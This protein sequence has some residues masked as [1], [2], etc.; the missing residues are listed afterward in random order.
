MPVPWILWV[1]L[2]WW[3]ESGWKHR[4]HHWIVLSAEALGLIWMNGT[5]KDDDDI[6]WKSTWGPVNLCCH[7]DLFFGG[8]WKWWKQTQFNITQQSS[9]L[10]SKDSKRQR[11]NGQGHFCA[12]VQ[13]LEE[14]E[15][16]GC[17]R[18]GG[19]CRL[20]WCGVGHWDS[21][22]LPS[23]EVDDYRFLTSTPWSFASQCGQV[24]RSFG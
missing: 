14:P 12:E 24:L 20:H 18:V 16:Q 8:G 9:K 23:G 3:I 4:L 10:W 19:G 1:H 5:S 13:L 11:S 7:P 17:H 15:W 2:S 21:A 22:L 6:S